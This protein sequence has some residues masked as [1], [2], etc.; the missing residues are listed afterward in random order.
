MQVR[1]CILES[2]STVRGGVV[3]ETGPCILFTE[4]SLLASELV[5]E[6]SFLFLNNQRHNRNSKALQEPR[7]YYFIRPEKDIED[8][9]KF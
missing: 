6:R 5:L 1:L 3:S 2:F 4:T 7:V 8:L 9:C